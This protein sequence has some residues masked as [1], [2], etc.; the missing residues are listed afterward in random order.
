VVAVGTA[1]ATAVVAPMLFL[2]VL[3]W[4]GWF[5]ALAGLVVLPIAGVLVGRALGGG[6]A[7]LAVVYP[8]MALL[9]GGTGVQG[10][11]QLWL[12]AQGETVRAVVAEVHEH[13]TKDGGV[14][15]SY[16][17]RH[18]GRGGL[19]RGG[20]AR[21]IGAGFVPGPKGATPGARAGTRVS[22]LE[23]PYGLVAPRAESSLDWG[24]WLAAWAVLTVVQG[25]LAYGVERG[26]LNSR[27]RRASSAD[28][29][30]GPSGSSDSSGGRP[31][32]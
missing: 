18:L 7:A 4:G 19:V 3:R 1:L 2:A 25:L 5:A 28:Q 22:V 32:V 21:H 31:A 6:R 13:H 30:P 24:R 16:V 26:A 17:L 10:G 11:G 23:D 20:E 8:V 12:L 14:N 15:Y 27:A 29:R 9:V